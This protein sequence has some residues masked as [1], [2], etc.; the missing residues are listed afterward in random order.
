MSHDVVFKTEN[1][2]KQI[3]WAEVYAPNV[4]DSDGEFMTADEIEKMAYDF[5]RRH[6]QESVDIFHTNEVPDGVCVVESFIARKGD[7]DFTEGAWVAGIH[8]P[9]P[10]TWGKIKK[11]EIN[12]FSMEAMV[13]KEVVEVEM[14]L[15][16]VIS[17]KTMKSEGH[18]HDFYVAYDESGKFQGGRTSKAEDGH[19]HLIRR[20]T[21]TEEAN[22][23]AHRFEHVTALTLAELS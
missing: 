8:V 3:V 7:P 22:G 19:F 10:E 1:D 17:A 16:A 4:P 23:H 2:E 20:G 18:D 9:D 11:G 12:G 14:E 15:P 21:V 5:M 13:H 6:K